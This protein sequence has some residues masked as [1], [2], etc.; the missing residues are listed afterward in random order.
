MTVRHAA[1]AV[2]TGMLCGT[3]LACGVCAEDKV[4]ATY[5]HA[6]VRQAAARGDVMVFCQVSGAPDAARL[7]AAALGV[8]G[9]KRRSVRVS[10]QPAALSFA[11]DPTQFPSAQAAVDRVQ[12]AAPPGTRLA[13]VRLQAGPT[14]AAQEGDR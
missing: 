13:I 8:R 6:V 12:Q 4:A 11:F 9:V 7:K 2:L 5:D 14:R 10:A 1:I 3:S